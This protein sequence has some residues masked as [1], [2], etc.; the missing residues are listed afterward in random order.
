MLNS[1]GALS[2]S[3]AGIDHSIDTM[4][5]AEFDHIEDVKVKTPRA[6]KEKSNKL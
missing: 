5:L 2:A 4:N 6:D 1:S 3:V